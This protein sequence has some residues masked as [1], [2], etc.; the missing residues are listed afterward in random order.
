MGWAVIII[1]SEGMSHLKTGSADTG[2]NNEAEYQALILALKTILPDNK[3]PVDIYT[4]SQLVYNQMLS[5]W[6][7]KDSRL[8]VLHRQATELMLA[9]NVS[10]FW[11]PRS[12]KRIK[13]ANGFAQKAAGVKNRH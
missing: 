1:P 5:N 2:T 6:Q 4:D 11:V 7:V 9:R 8:S 3:V 13:Q 12:H 10:L